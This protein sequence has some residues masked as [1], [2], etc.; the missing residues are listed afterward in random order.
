[1][2]KGTFIIAIRLPFCLPFGGLHIFIAAEALTIENKHSKILTAKLIQKHIF[3][4]KILEIFLV[5]FFE[6]K[7]ITKGLPF[8][9]RFKNINIDFN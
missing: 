7:F 6:W 8:A 4:N 2:F 5:Y 3:Q 9:N 1:M